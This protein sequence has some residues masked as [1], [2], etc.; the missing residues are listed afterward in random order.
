MVAK[1]KAVKRVTKKRV[2][3]RVIKKKAAKPARKSTAQKASHTRKAAAAAAT[4]RPPAGDKPPAQGSLLP[5]TEL[6]LADQIVDSRLLLPQKLCAAAFGISAQAFQAWKIKPRMKRGREN[7]Y[8]L[9]D[10]IEYRLTRDQHGTL[11]LGEERARL[12]SAQADRAELEVKQLT[13]ELIPAAVILE[14]W[15]PVVG[16]ARAKVLAI[17]SK[18]KTA[19][20]RLKDAELS[21]L[22]TICRGVLEDLA[23][24]GI[25][26]SV[27]PNNRAGV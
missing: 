2:P 8:Y 5:E 3:A 23:N 19:I 4:T 11:N 15:E 6:S 1:K 21:K 24:N 17:P 7:L 12:A 20:P 16:A 26:K 10:C 22:K 14:S 18:A 9:P 25:P 13:G 27:K